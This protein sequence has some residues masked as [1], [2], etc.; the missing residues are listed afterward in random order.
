MRS[1]TQRD[2]AKARYDVGQRPAAEI[3]QRGASGQT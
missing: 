3:H 1:N 2:L